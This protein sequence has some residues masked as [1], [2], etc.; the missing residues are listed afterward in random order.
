MTH[1][2]TNGRRDRRRGWSLAGGGGSCLR[3]R[4][5]ETDRRIGPGGIGP[6][7]LIHALRLVRDRIL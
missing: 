4:L 6:G 5:A 3:R 1:A 2:S 7:G